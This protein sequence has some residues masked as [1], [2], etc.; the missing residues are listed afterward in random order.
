MKVIGILLGWGRNERGYRWIDVEGLR[1]DAGKNGVSDSVL[2]SLL[3]QEVVAYVQVDFR[4]QEGGRWFVRRRLLAIRKA[5][6]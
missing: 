1:L 5:E 4:R 6:G 3:G 2:D